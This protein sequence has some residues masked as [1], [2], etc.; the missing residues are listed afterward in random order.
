MIM[1]PILI[2]PCPTCCCWSRETVLA[3]SAVHFLIDSKKSLSEIERVSSELIH[4]SRR[5]PSISSTSDSPDVLYRT[6]GR[7]EESGFL[8]LISLRTSQRRFPPPTSGFRRAST[9]SQFAGEEAMS[10][11]SRAA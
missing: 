6:E 1:F 7:A 3:T 2:S 9:E 5:D 10:G 8:A 4:A 11:F